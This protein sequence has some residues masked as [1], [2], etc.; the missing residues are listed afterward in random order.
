M[1]HIF[2]ILGWVSAFAVVALIVYLE[3]IRPWHLRWGATNEEVKLP[4]PG[5]DIV[6]I[7]KLQA[8]HAVTIQAPAAMVWPWLVQMGQGRGGLYSYDWLENL[9]GLNIHSADRILPE[10]QNL[11]VGDVL[12]LEPGGTGP[13]VVAIWPGRVLVLG[14]KMSGGAGGGESPFALHDKNAESYMACSWIFFLQPVNAGTTRLI[15]RFR[16]DW[17]E[18]W[19]YT[20]LSRAVLE[21]A[22]FIME[23]KM[24]LGIKRRAEA[25]GTQEAAAQ[26]RAASVAP[27]P[28][29]SN[30]HSRG[31]SERKA[32]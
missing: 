19:K 8:T 21:P 26:L 31:S 27:K 7:P 16:L 20:L 18:S 13:P 25:L 3:A 11:K 6:L 32:S 1:S 15:E 12:P 30:A 17:N 22:S 24:L 23:R 9:M 2:L 5:D 28:A 14:G 10:C 4:L 29:G